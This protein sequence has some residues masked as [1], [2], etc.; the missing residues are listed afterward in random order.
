SHA[1]FISKMG[2][3]EEEADESCF[4]IDI[5]SETKNIAKEKVDMLLSEARELTVI[6]TAS[7]KT[8]KSNRSK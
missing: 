7:C 5:M 6:F 2:I 3:V 1:E 8:A 4:W